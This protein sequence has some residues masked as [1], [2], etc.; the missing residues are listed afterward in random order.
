MANRFLAPLGIEVRRRVSGGGVR[1]STLRG[2]LGYLVAL[3]FKPATVIDVGVGTGTAPLYELFPAARHVLIEPLVEYAPAIDAI[4]GSLRRAEHVRAAASSAPGE[5]SLRLAAE[6]LASVYPLRDPRYPTVETRTVPATTLDEIWRTR[7]L[8][9]PVL[10][11]MDVDGQ[12]LDV[13]AG[14]TEVM[15]RCEYLVLETGVREV[16][17]GAP[18]FEEVVRRLTDQGW[19]VEDVLDPMYR[20]GHEMLTMVDLAFVPKAGWVRRATES[21]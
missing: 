15:A 12:E 2:A 9:G 6:N 21:G 8:E 20:G 16:L 17:V 14:A 13:L 1:R 11:K 4:V 18:R 19:A 3:G 5:L 10:V 7:G